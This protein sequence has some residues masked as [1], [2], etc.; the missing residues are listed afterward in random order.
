MAEG[1]AKFYGGGNIEPYSAGSNPSGTINPTAIL[2]MKE[3]GIDI[4]NNISK[5]FDSMPAIEFDIL[6]TMGC[7][8]NCP[9]ISA[10]KRIGWNIRDPKGEPLEIF[11]MVRDE[12]EEKVKGLLSFL[13]GSAGVIL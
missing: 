8:E 10:K 9:F 11:G 12:I 13:K 4:S 3:K 6:I 1:F 2:V 5:Y 7:G